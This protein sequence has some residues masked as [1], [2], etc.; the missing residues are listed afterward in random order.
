MPHWIVMRRDTDGDVHR[1]DGLWEAESAE[2]AV[3]RMLAKTGK[4]DDGNWDAEAADEREDLMNWQLDKESKG[5]PKP[6][7]EIDK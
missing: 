2:A 1:V 3:A 6:S 5:K 4:T 7:E